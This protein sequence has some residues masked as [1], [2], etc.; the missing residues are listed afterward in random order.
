MMADTALTAV[1]FCWLM[2]SVFLLY[3]TRQHWKRV[4][5]LLEHERLERAQ[6]LDRLMAR[7]FA[8][9]KTAESLVEVTRE[10]LNR[11]DELAGIGLE[12]VGV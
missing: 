12:D 2:T 5:E 6:L 1:V 7:D 8:Q 11:A 9:F 4:N 10:E 3:E